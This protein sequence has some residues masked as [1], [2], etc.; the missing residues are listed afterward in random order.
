[1]ESR[2]LGELIKEQVIMASTISRSPS[3]AARAA[4]AAAG[5]AGDE[6]ADNGR[7]PEADG[8][9]D[10][11]NESD[12]QNG[13]VDGSGD[14]EPTSAPLNPAATRPVDPEMEARRAAQVDNPNEP[15]AFAMTPEDIAVLQEIKR[16]GG[17]QGLINA[18]RTELDDDRR[19]A[20]GDRASVLQ[21]SAVKATGVPTRKMDLGKEI[22]MGADGKRYGPGEVDVPET[23]VNQF[24]PSET[25]ASLLQKRLDVVSRN[26]DQRDA[27]RQ[28]EQDEIRRAARRAA[29]EEDD[30]DEEE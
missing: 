3:P 15:T 24:N 18:I 26:R 29:K 16:H 21:S 17:I 1:M 30:E 5:A 6:E 11:G 9:T 14:E 22:I 2:P 12:E 25:V 13:P 23:V 8:A 27:D 4:R 28:R 20:S 10:E 19:A 7:N